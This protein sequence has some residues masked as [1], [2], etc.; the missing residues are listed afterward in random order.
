MFIFCRGRW[1]Q[2]GWRKGKKIQGSTLCGKRSLSCVPQLASS[3]SQPN[4]SLAPGV[5]HPTLPSLSNF[6]LSMFGADPRDYVSTGKD[7]HKRTYKKVGWV[8][9][10]SVSWVRA[11]VAALACYH[12]LWDKAEH[13]KKSHQRDAAVPPWF[14]ST[15]KEHVACFE[16]FSCLHH[17]CPLLQVL[18]GFLAHTIMRKMTL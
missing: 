5:S 12:C 10:A 2:L 3:Q 6:H 1:W 7:E 18:P 15:P 11:Y 14:N 13:L 9:T 17:W 16:W 4:R 8:V